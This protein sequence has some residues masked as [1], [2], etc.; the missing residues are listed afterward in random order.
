MSNSTNSL[1]IKVC[2]GTTC[3]IFGSESLTRW[4]M[5]LKNSGIALNLEETSCTG[6]CL[7]API[8]LWNQEPIT[9][10]SPQKLTHQLIREDLAF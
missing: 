2:Q 4:G 8:A 7:E 5:D 10:C 3:N 9:Q 6:H 1:T